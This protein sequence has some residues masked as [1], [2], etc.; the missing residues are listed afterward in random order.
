MLVTGK[1]SFKTFSLETLTDE[2]L[3]VVEAPDV[4]DAV[5]LGDAHGALGDNV[6]DERRIQ[7]LDV[8][9]GIDGVLPAVV[10]GGKL[11][12]VRDHGLGGELDTVVVKMLAKNTLLECSV[13]KRTGTAG[14]AY[15][16]E[17]ATSWERRLR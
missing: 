13:C 12:V 9:D 6:H 17:S 1:S 16:A 7:A 5:V 4:A 14:W 15:Q 11:V 10:D 8:G 2:G 3:A